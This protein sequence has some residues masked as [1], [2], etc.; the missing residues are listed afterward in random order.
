M[1]KYKKKVLQKMFVFYYK[2]NIYKSMIIQK[3][4]NFTEKSQI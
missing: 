4:N 1:Q 3:E 2:S